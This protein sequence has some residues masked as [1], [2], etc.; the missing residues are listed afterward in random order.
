MNFS[1]FLKS[2]SIIFKSWEHDETLN[3]Y[4]DK[5]N[6]QKEFLSIIQKEIGSNFIILSDKELRKEKIKFYN[7]TISNYEY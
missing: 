3:K 2:V 7:E 1:D 6:L 5:E 4:N